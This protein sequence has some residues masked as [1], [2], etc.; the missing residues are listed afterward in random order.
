MSDDGSLVGLYTQDFKSLCAAV[1]TYA[2]VVHRN[3]HFLHCDLEKYMY[4]R[5][6]R[7]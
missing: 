2:N 1:T 4:S 7:G 6:D 5:M 3:F